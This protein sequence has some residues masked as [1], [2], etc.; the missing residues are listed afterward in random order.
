MQWCQVMRSVA[1]VTQ[2]HLPKTEDLMLP[3]ANPLRKSAPG[4]WWTCVLYCACYG[5]CIL[6]DPLEMSHPCH[7]FSKCYET[8]TFCSLL[9]RCPIPSACHAKRNLKV[10]KWPEHVMCL[11]FDFEMCFSPQRRALFR[12]LNSTSKS[13][14]NPAVFL[15]FDFGICFP[16]QRRALFRHLNFQ[17]WSENGFAHFDLEMCFAPQ[18]RVTRFCLLPT[19]RNQEFIII[20]I[21]LMIDDKN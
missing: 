11:T 8:I 5:K 14:P 19:W 1:P 3:K 6:P 21:W 10:Q 12:H 15:H 13:A 4:L 18:R 16:V 17:K 20:D 7:R 2:N 9:T